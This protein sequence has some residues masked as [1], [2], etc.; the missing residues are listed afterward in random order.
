MPDHLQ[1]RTSDMHTGKAR[2][3]R[4]SPTTIIIISVLVTVVAGI[5]LLG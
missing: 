4:I 2:K 3:P 5:M 1:S